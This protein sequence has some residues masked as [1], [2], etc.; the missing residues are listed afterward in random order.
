MSARS[1]SCLVLGAAFLLT[2]PL[3]S[4]GQDVSGEVRVETGRLSADRTS[5]GSIRGRVLLPNGRL[6]EESLKVTLLTV[7]GPQAWT[8]TENHG[9]FEFLNL[10]PGNYEVQIETIGVH[11][12]VVSQAVQVLR[13]APS[14][15]TISLNENRDAKPQTASSV[16]SVNELSASI[17]RAARKE[18]T[19]AGEAERNHKTD[20]AIGHLRKAIEI[21]PAFA[22]ARSDLGVQLFSQGK[23]D[24]AEEQFREA[25]KLDGDA[26]NPRLNLGIILV[27]KLEYVEALVQLNRA[28]SLNPESASAQL[29][30]GVAYVGLEQYEDAE[31]HLKSAYTIGGTSYS[32]ALYHLGRLYT[33]KGEREAA[34]KY[35]QEYLRV[36]PDA[37]NA[38][39]VEKLI[40]MLQSPEFEA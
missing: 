39:Q 9:S 4:F 32:L 1:S 26:F 23:L 34:L 33:N 14:M 6:V 36:S 16:V 7:N 29:Y 38:H 17:P 2:I 31:K 27:E 3:C 8:Y 20:E 21:Y 15:M 18:F 22:M 37:P 40:A 28:I 35:F 19:L 30:T 13:G 24:E 5:R 25:I 10:V 11:Y 12:Q